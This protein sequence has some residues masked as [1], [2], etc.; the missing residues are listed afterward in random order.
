MPSLGPDQYNLKY[1]L[2]IYLFFLADNNKN[3]KLLIKSVLVLVEVKFDDVDDRC[4]DS[5]YED[6]KMSF[7]KKKSNFD[8]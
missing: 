6:G 3:I 1:F 8:R 5:N 4:S 2:F 7:L